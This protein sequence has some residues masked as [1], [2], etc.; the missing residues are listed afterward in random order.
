MIKAQNIVYIR[1][2][3]RGVIDYVG[4]LRL[5]C[6]W[7]CFSYW[8]RMFRVWTCTIIRKSHRNGCKRINKIRA[9]KGSFFRIFFIIFIRG[10][11]ILLYYICNGINI[12]KI[13]YILVFLIYL[14]YTI[15]EWVYLF[16]LCF[17][18][19]KKLKIFYIFRIDLDAIFIIQYKGN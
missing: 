6:V 3:E 12:K 5:L 7:Y 8:M 9:K 19:R 2:Y 10:F 4:F 13:E 17:I 14:T 11:L 16:F 1:F 18:Y 15:F